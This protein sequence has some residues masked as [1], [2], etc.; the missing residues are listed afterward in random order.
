MSL[1][2]RCS[3]LSMRAKDGDVTK[4]QYVW[5]GLAVMNATF[6]TYNAMDG[7]WSGVVFNAV[8][9]AVALLLSGLPQILAR[10][11]LRSDENA[12]VERFR[13]SDVR[14]PPTER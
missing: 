12:S 6:A 8:I 7:A 1:K 2:Q 9:C 14:G 4:F 10:R 13:E 3:K 5:L 11:I